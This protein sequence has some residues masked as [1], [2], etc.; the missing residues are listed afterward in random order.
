M[1]E[2]LLIQREDRVVTLTM[3]RPERKNAINIAMYRALT[4]AISTAGEDG[5]RVIVLTGAGANFTSGNDL[6][7]FAE[8]T[9]VLDRDNPIAGFIKA[10]LHCPIPLVVAVEGVAVGIGTTVLLHSDLV[11]AAASAKFRLPFVNLGLCPEFASS[12]VL[13]RLA[14]HVKAAEW[15][16]LGEF[17]TAADA[18][19]AR[20]IN[21]IDDA[22]LRLAQAKA[23][24]LAAQPPAALRNAKRLMK[25][26]Q[27]GV[28][29]S[30]IQQEFQ[31][32]GEALKGP[33][34][35]EAATAF[36]EKRPADF[37]AF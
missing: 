30:I 29:E 26:T 32:F 24:Q 14:G 8:A 22:P 3:N 12:H 11:F 20:L 34:F 27:M 5:T 25:S 28:L 13:S 19:D 7:D 1:T 37:S 9:N 6:A 4:N 31:T 35:A 16:M 23:K 33:E 15:L 17:F 21:A 36:F 10:V 2:E 18:K